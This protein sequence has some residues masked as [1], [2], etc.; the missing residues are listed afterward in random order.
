[1]VSRVQYNVG[2][3]TPLAE[4]NRWHTRRAAQT[5]G[6]AISISPWGTAYAQDFFNTSFLRVTPDGSSAIRVG[7]AGKG[8]GEFSGMEAAGFIGDTLVI[9]DPQGQR[10]TFFRDDGTVARIEAWDAR[11]LTPTKPPPPPRRYKVEAI[12]DDGT[13]LSRESVGGR[14][15]TDWTSLKTAF[16]PVPD[17]I[18]RFRRPALSE[19]G[20]TIEIDS[21][22][23]LQE[24]E[25]G[26]P[27]FDATSVVFSVDQPWLDGDLFVT[28]P[29]GRLSVRVSR[30]APTAAKASY[31][32]EGYRYGKRAFSRVIPYTA[33]AITDDFVAEWTERTIGDDQSATL[34]RFATSNKRDPEQY[35]DIAVAR[36]EF[37]KALYRPS[38]APAVR[39]LVVGRDETIWLRRE[40]SGTGS[41]EWEVRDWNGN[42]I[43]AI[44]V[45]ETTQIMAATRL[46][47][48]GLEKD[49][50][51][52]PLIVRYVVRR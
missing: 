11:G 48:W 42:Q 37:R 7:R 2:P 4:R 26:F 46:V 12:L 10:L 1:M 29:D 28:S 30:M 20:K 32:I 17:V 24:K 18:Y 27:I 22:M 49:E 21:V 50:D 31:T 52:N 35:K 47:V 34:V 33:R 25:N 38:F 8:P 51:G 5:V 36:T 43:A 44:T 15:P 9:Y 45:P 41:A 6:V 19:S 3:S 40:W 13:V 23:T 39:N 16:L 14:G